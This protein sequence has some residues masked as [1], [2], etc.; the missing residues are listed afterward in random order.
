MIR[1]IKCDMSRVFPS[2]S[3]LMAVL[4][5]F[6]LCFME[7]IYVD[8][9]TM[10]TFSVL[11]ALFRFDRTFMEG[12]VSFSA[13]AVFKTAFSG[14]SAIF[15]PILASFPF[16]YSQSAERNSGNIRFLIFRAR[17]RNYY[18]SKFVCAVLS[19][20]MCIM[21]GVALFGSFVFFVFPHAADYASFYSCDNIFM[22]IVKKLCSSFLYG[23]AN[24]ISAFSSARFAAI[25][26]SFFVFLF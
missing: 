13:L 23:C 9:S 2:I 17:R 14:Y 20:G 25:A 12:N 11:E 3:F 6:L 1:M 8:S 22:E 26:I 18:L 19:G 16:V 7:D 10:Q 4:V 5:T 15:L 21:T 24:T